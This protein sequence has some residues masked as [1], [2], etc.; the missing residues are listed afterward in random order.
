MKKAILI[1]PLIFIFGTLACSSTTLP[2]TPE[3]ASATETV[4]VLAPAPGSA[5][6]ENSAPGQETVPDGAL[7]APSGLRVVYLRDGNL[8]SWTEP[9][10]IVQLT[11][12]GDIST[13]R[14]SND[15][16]SLAYMRGSEVWIV[17]IDGQNARLLATQKDTGGVLWFAPNGSLLAV[18]TQDHIDVINL[19]EGGSTTVTTYPGIQDG[20][21]PEVVWAPDASGFKTVIPS[22]TRTGQAQFLFVFTNGT[23]ANL[24]KFALV[25]LS[26]SLPHLS[27]D[28]GYIIYAAK[29]NE[30]KESLY[31]M[32]SSG[33]TKPYG[34]AASHV[35]ALD[36]LPDSRHFA[37]TFED[38]SRAF[39]GNVAGSP[40]EIAL[41]GYQ[42]LRWVDEERFLGLQ[43]DSLYLG[44]IN[45][46]KTLIDM[47][48]SDFDF[49]L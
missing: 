46:G 30:G 4:S 8:W 21:A 16:Q 14:L 31:L 22:Q 9:A 6:T 12:T 18:S 33:A 34:E 3:P 15:G 32:D 43:D 39:L 47:Q 13:L 2:A 1:F 35:R 23:V 37:Y 27:P 36:W 49:G 42:E 48:V 5:P 45:G 29:L 20:Y 28:G 26:E 40:V 19:Q 38:S 25:P 7:S 11:D 17:G 10:G 41:E 44:D 24:A